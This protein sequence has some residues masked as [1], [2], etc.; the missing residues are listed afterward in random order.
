MGIGGAA[1]AGQHNI[2]G[3][4]RLPPNFSMKEH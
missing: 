1:P 2:G 3:A 4:V